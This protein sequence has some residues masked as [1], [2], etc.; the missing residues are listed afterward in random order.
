MVFALRIVDAAA[1]T[2]A[3]SVSTRTVLAVFGAPLACRLRGTLLKDPKVR[4]RFP[5]GTGN[6]GL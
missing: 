6:K 3:L 2:F 5:F 4:G 1:S